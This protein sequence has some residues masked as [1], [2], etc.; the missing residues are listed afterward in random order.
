M[1]EVAEVFGSRLQDR[2]RSFE[3]S[4]F[5]FDLFEHFLHLL[6]LGILASEIGS[7]LSEVVPLHILSTLSSGIL[8]LLVSHHL[9]QCLLFNLQ[10][11][12]LLL[13]LLFL[14]F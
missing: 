10:L 6:V 14:I 9:F 2:L 7:V 4:Y 13:F 3:N 8:C 11:L 12:Y 5:G 1:H